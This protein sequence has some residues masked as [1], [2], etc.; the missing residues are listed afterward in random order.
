[1]ENDDEFI[2][3]SND[4]YKPAGTD[5]DALDGAGTGAVK[6]READYTN[7]PYYQGKPTTSRNSGDSDNQLLDA[8]R[9]VLLP[10]HR[11]RKVAS[12]G[13]SS[14]M[15]EQDL[16]NIWDGVSDWNAGDADK[17]S[18]QNQDP[19][20]DQ[21]LER[22]NNP[23]G[24]NQSDPSADAYERSLMQNQV[25]PDFKAWALEMK[26]AAEL[27]ADA[28]DK[29]TYE[30]LQKAMTNMYRLM[31]QNTEGALN[32]LVSNL[33]PQIIEQKLSQQSS[34]AQ[35]ASVFNG[36]TQSLP[37]GLRGSHQTHIMRPIFQTAVELAKGDMNLAQRL[38]SVQVKKAFPTFY[39]SEAGNGRS[40][41]DYNLGNSNN[42]Q[43]KD[44]ASFISWLQNE[45]SR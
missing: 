39:A 9:Q 7:D 18:G 45:K 10:E 8:L 29:F 23:Q 1:M 37:Q 5:R 3:G 27:G 33:M 4:M 35:V 40:Q 19:R 32:N 30:T 43:N 24:S 36:W 34:K 41:V 26:A 11:Q 14:H 13:G 38:A 25:M 22:M 6:T 28:Q 2:T 21:L 12:L 15:S 42:R 17:A 16:M 20:M 44:Q 31:G